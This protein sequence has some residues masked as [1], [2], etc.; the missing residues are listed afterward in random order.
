MIQKVHA[1]GGEK[2]IGVSGEAQNVRPIYGFGTTGV[3]GLLLV[4]DEGLY[5][6]GGDLGNA[7]TLKEDV[8]CD[9]FS[10]DE[11][12]AAFHGRKRLADPHSNSSSTSI[13]LFLVGCDIT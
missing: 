2:S 10:L 7:G 9:T 4:I 6:T 13:F 8:F 1:R 5:K 11:T 3:V 12:T